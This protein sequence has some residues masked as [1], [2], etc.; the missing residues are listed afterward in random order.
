MA[1]LILRM[2]YNTVA[3]I[4]ASVGKKNER[5]VEFNFLKRSEDIQSWPVTISLIIPVKCS[6]HNVKPF[7]TD[8]TRW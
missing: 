5:K 2:V 4:I 3:G 7:I 8:M 1:P 6:L